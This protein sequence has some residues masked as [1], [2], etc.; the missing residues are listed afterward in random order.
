MVFSDS[1]SDFDFSFFSLEDRFLFIGVRGL[2]GD[3]FRRELGGSVE[4]F[5][6]GFMYLLGYF[7]GS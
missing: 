1:D 3:K 4:V 7:F 2:K 6:M 5:R